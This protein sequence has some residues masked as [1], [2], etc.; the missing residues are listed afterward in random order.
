M[1]DVVHLVFF[2]ILIHTLY[3]N[4]NGVTVNV[5]LSP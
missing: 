2:P 5:N 3:S 4:A 1:W